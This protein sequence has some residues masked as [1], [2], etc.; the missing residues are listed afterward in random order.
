LISICAVYFASAASFLEASGAG[1]EEGGK[2]AMPAEFLSPTVPDARPASK[3]SYFLSEMERRFGQVPYFL[4]GSLS[5]LFLLPDISIRD[6]F[7]VG[8]TQEFVHPYLAGATFLVIDRKQKIP[9]P[10]LSC[11]KWAQPVF[12]LQQRDGT[13]L[14]GFCSLQNHWLIFRSCLAG[15]PK[16]VR[17]R[18]RVEAEVVGKVVGVVRRLQ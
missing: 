14:C 6:V 18:H 5:S 13:H 10:S 9:R 7:W 17:L 4:R 2:L 8:G 12:V 15:T 1:L 16:L 3:P 11:P